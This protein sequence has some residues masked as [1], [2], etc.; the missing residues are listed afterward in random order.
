MCF[1][2]FTPVCTSWFAGVFVI[3]SLF[4]AHLM[5][6]QMYSC[7]A[8]H[9][10]VFLLN[11]VETFGSRFCICTAFASEGTSSSCVVFDACPPLWNSA[12][13]NHSR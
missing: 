8:V 5:I 7:L 1:V 13:S 4:A 10:T 12:P 6:D 3:A 11:S 9:T 2:C